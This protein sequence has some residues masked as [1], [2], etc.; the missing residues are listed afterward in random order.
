MLQIC[1]KARRG[2]VELR[3]LSESYLKNH[4]QKL[5]YISV[6]D[7]K[8]TWF[9]D[10]FITFDVSVSIYTKRGREDLLSKYHALSLKVVYLIENFTSFRANFVEL[11]VWHERNIRSNFL[12]S[13]KW[14]FIYCNNFVDLGVKNTSLPLCMK[15]GAFMA[16]MYTTEFLLIQI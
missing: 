9:E 15:A 2:S 14:I 16:Y 12:V 13:L 10:S 7:F 3:A 4:L 5:W 6:T 8:Q 11:S 1:S